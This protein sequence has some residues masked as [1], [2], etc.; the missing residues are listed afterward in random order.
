MPRSSNRDA[1]LDAF[2]A[3]LGDDGERAATLDAVAER[4]GV[5]KG[6]LLYHFGSKEQLVAGLVER[7]EHLVADDVA[8]LR[9]DPDG[10]VVAFLRSS[11]A[12]DGPLDRT[13]VALARVAQDDRYPEAR[14]AMRDME[15]A[16]RAVVDEAVAD[17]PLVARIVTLVSDGLYYSSVLGVAGVDAAASPA[18]SRREVDEIA[19][20]LELLRRT[21]AG[22]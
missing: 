18:V 20:A 14:R 1:L 21:R 13:I 15:R 9:A 16:W 12:D 22:G 5:S 7:L 19:G 8:A 17:D 11:S 2:T 4:A 10:A 3:I 6:G